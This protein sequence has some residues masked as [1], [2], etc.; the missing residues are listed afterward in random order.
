M[1]ELGSSACTAAEAFPGWWEDLNSHHDISTVSMSYL[2][3][4]NVGTW[5]KEQI[6]KWFTFKMY[7]IIKTVLRPWMGVSLEVKHESINAPVISFNSV[8]MSMHTVTMKILSLIS[9]VQPLK[10]GEPDCNCSIYSLMFNLEVEVAREPVVEERLVDI[11][12]GFQLCSDPVL[13]LVTTDVHGDV[14]HLSCPHKPVALQKPK[15]KIFIY[16]MH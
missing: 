5:Y 8:I 7:K 15:N 4:T 2:L 11:A 14:V 3:T 6:L 9:A 16:K 12:R 10:S 1:T 13:I